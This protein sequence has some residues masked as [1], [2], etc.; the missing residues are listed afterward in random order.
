MRAIAII[1]PITIPAI[2]P[3]DR[4]TW[5]SVIKGALTLSHCLTL[6]SNC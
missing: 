5:E 6:S 2:A 4:P 1:I 3:P